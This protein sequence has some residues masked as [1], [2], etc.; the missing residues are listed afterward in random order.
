MS[1]RKREADEDAF[2]E[3]VEPQ[4]PDSKLSAKSKCLDRSLTPVTNVQDAFDSM[5]QCVF[6]QIKNIAGRGGFGLR[7]ATMCSGTES[8]ILALKMLQ[9]AWSTKAEDPFLSVEHVFSVEIDP[10]KQ[11]FLARNVDEGAI[12][13]QDVV[14]FAV[15]GGTS[16]RTALGGSKEVPKDIDLLIAGCS[17]VDFSSLNTNK[18]AKFHP[19]VVNKAKELARDQKSTKDGKKQPLSLEGLADLFTIIAEHI[20]AS[21]RESEQ[22]FFGMLAYVKIHQP[23]MVILENVMNAPWDDVKNLWFPCVGY[24]AEYISLDTKNYYIPHTRT[25]GYL[26]ALRCGSFGGQENTARILASWKDCLSILRRRASSPVTDWMLPA[27]HPL[28]LRARQDESAKALRVKG[29]ENSWERSM[30]RHVRVRRDNQLGDK[31]PL[32]EWGSRGDKPSL[33]TLDKLNLAY[34]NDRA[35]DCIDIHF[36]RTLLGPLSCDARYKAWVVDLSQNI[37]RSP[38]GPVGI[39]QC[40]TPRGQPF[41]FDQG[42]IVSGFEAL[43][44]Q[45]MPLEM[46]DLSRET[47]DQLRDLAG[48]AMT[49]TVVGAA[50][51]ALFCALQEVFEVRTL[52]RKANPSQGNTTEKI[53]LPDSPDLEAEKGHGTSVYERLHDV[54]KLWDVVSKC[55]RYCFC[56]RAAR[57]ST[58]D[59]R[60]CVICGVIRCKWCA[61]NPPHEFTHFDGPTEPVSLD[62]VA[63]EVMRFFPTAIEK[64]NPFSK[65]AYPDRQWTLAGSSNVIKA[66]ESTVFYYTEVQTTEVITICYAGISE[67]RDAAFSLRVVLT[68]RDRTIMWYLHMDPCSKVG[69]AAYNELRERLGCPYNGKYRDTSCNKRLRLEG[70]DTFNFTLDDSEKIRASQRPFARLVMDAECKYGALDVLPRLDSWELWS[71][72]YLFFRIN[73]RRQAMSQTDTTLMSY[74]ICCVSSPEELARLPDTVRENLDL[75]A[76]GEY[77]EKPGCEA[78]ENSLS[79][80]EEKSTFFFK[81]PL[82]TT[83]PHADFY[84]ISKDCRKLENQEFREILVAFKPDFNPKKLTQGGEQA[85][86]GRVH[87]Y[88]IKPRGSNVMTDSEPNRVPRVEVLRALRTLPASCELSKLREHRDTV[89]AEV[90]FSDRLPDD[91][92]KLLLQLQRAIGDKRDHWVVVPNRNKSQLSKLIAPVTVKLASSTLLKRVFDFGVLPFDLS[93][94]RP[95]CE[96]CSPTMPRVFWVRE[97]DTDLNAHQV[98]SDMTTFAECNGK[99]RQALQIHASLLQ[100]ESTSRSANLAL[101]YVIDPLVLAHQSYV[102]LPKFQTC[103][104]IMEDPSIACPTIHSRV[105]IHPRAAMMPKYIFEG[106]RASLKPL[107]S[108]G[109]EAAEADQPPNFSMTLTQLQRQSLHWMLVHEGVLSTTPPQTRFQEIEEEEVMIPELQLRMV[110]RATRDVCRFGGILADDAGYGKTVISLALIGRQ[111]DFD[112]GLSMKRRAKASQRREREAMPPCHCIP[113]KATLVVVPPHLVSQWKDQAKVCL[114]LSGDEIVAIKLMSSLLEPGGVQSLRKKFEAARIIIVNRAIFSNKHYL[115]AFALCAGGL[116]P[117]EATGDKGHRAFKDWYEEALPYV[118]ANSE[119]LYRALDSLQSLKAEYREISQERQSMMEAYERAAEDRGRYKQSVRS[120][121]KKTSVP[122]PAVAYT[123]VVDHKGVKS[124]YQIFEFYSYARVIYD[125]F[126]YDDPSTTLFVRNAQA[127]AKWIL[128]ATPPTRDLAAICSTGDLL[129]VHVA[130]PLEIRYGF[131]RVT[132]GPPNPSLTNAETQ[133]TYNKLPSDQ[134]V[135]QRHE[136][137]HAFLKHYASANP[138]GFNIEKEEYVVTSQLTQ[139]SMIQYLDFQQELRKHGL[140]LQELP[141]E[142]YD[143]LPGDLDWNEDPKGGAMAAMLL[144]YLASIRAPVRDILEMRKMLLQKAEAYIKQL[145]EKI[146]FLGHRIVTDK[147]EMGKTNAQVCVPDIASLLQDILE[148]RNLGE[149]GGYTTWKTIHDAVFPVAAKASTAQGFCRYLNGANNNNNNYVAFFTGLVETTGTKWFDHYRLQLVE[150]KGKKDAE[151]KK[152]VELF[153]FPRQSEILPLTHALFERGELP[154]A[155]ASAGTDEETCKAH[156]LSWSL[157]QRKA[158]KNSQS[159]PRG[160]NKGKSKGKS[161]LLSQCCKLGLRARSYDTI[162]VLNNLLQRH[163]D[164]VATV[165]DY[166]V[167]AAFNFSLAEYPYYDASKVVRGSL[168]SAT[169]QEATD[170]WLQVMDALTNIATLTKQTQTIKVLQQERS[171]RA[172]DACG[173]HAGLVLITECGHVVCDTCR[174]GKDCCADLTTDENHIIFKCPS[175]LEHSAVPLDALFAEGDSVDPKLG[176]EKTQRII[177]CIRT[178][179]GEDKVLLFY[180]YDA[181]YRALRSALDE[182]GIDVEVSS[183]NVEKQPKVRLMKLNDPESAGLD[184]QYANHVMFASPL[185]VDSQELYDMYMRQALGRAVRHG[186]KKK[187]HIYHFVTERTVE[188]DILR[189]R[190]RSTIY[191]KSGEPDPH[192]LRLKPVAADVAETEEGDPLRLNSLLSAGEVWKM[193]KEFNFLTMIGMEE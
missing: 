23:K 58:E 14:D 25:R 187:V 112:A 3:D 9:Q 157:N 170:T 107:S 131:P 88:W 146:I 177:E 98:H 101:R 166:V 48:N 7:V 160:A 137:G 37:D 76:P 113:L 167:G 120:T 136:Q 69:A 96:A 49:T 133:M 156:L 134:I 100:T 74:K 110:G 148:K 53:L 109:S 36:L 41:M 108:G 45:G 40:V 4:D 119:R 31:Q 44:L 143:L 182:A 33:D 68:G 24:S 169:V 128:S 39:A 171:E 122:R 105:E 30:I 153:P 81:D 158:D 8:P 125:E 185:V 147:V 150:K 192:M 173:T 114:G 129:G 139:S 61:R 144:L 111:K 164:G 42:R 10:F 71:Y 22:T 66:L 15:N 60:K 86:E 191:W 162:P 11:A 2:D 43:A 130:R 142:V 26:L 90:L 29:H 54:D 12:I 127:Y 141:K 115:N 52:F 178:K 95:L 97:T 70:A 151:D 77:V 94:S 165:D 174:R 123:P 118:R 188:V 161:E 6:E 126:S 172:C 117:P 135:H 21:D 155:Q 72:K 93:D 28:T 190:Q 79:H 186:Q 18:S 34:L 87:G 145:V 179:T 27:S 106:F 163:H 193:M 149:F 67:D 121:T 73:L 17:C 89:L 65:T 20:P 181:Q 92:Q 51:L 38:L 62:Q 102:L 50:Q 99:R 154:S 168:A 5:I 75:V 124:F 35:N 189:L 138:L 91:K 175:V 83:E 16:A 103:L 180:Q 176:S 140:D 13:F 152:L 85:C 82:R 46:L 80:C 32:T 84:V 159:K 104:D 57:Y 47:Q 55:C 132:Q 184:L 56:N 64:L 63:A 183:E 78:A 19:D 59:Y 1:K 116:T